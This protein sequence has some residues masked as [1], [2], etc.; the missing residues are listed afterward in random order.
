MSIELINKVLKR[1]LEGDTSVRVDERD[2][3]ADMK[4]FAQTINT[5]IEKLEL[6]REAEVFKKRMIAFVKFNP[7]AIAVL[8]PDKKRIDLNK[9]YQRAWRGNFKELMSKKLYDF[10]INI[11][12][13]DD[14]YASYTTKRTATTDMEISW[15]DNT[16]TNLRL[17]QMPILNE[18]GEIDVNY[19][20][21][22][23]LTAETVLNKYM[24]TEVDKISGNIEKISKGDLEL[25]LSVADAD[26]Y[27]KGAREMMLEISLSLS[28]A[29]NAIQ[30]LVA[31]AELLSDAAINGN[32]S[33]RT[34]V[35]KH[36]GHF[37]G[38]M[39]GFN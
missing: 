22:Q 8:G 20:I 24:H 39:E 28:K 13:G 34:D 37:R 6:A 1:A 23:D 38:V 27:T 18:N 16:K 17:Y 14:F 3:E 35:T 30:N 32:I 19:Y 11:T 4:D 21:Y 29:K 2:V 36:E 9:E 10:N 31:D 15:P 33:E 25:D 5:V 12:G 26:A 7:Q